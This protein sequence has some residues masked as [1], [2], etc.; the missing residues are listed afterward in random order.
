MNVN[1]S[2]ILFG[3]YDRSSCTFLFRGFLVFADLLA[4]EVRG[5][6]GLISWEGI[7]SSSKGKGKGM[8][9]EEP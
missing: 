3:E 1:C 9:L 5:L 6:G 4:K 8:Q 7:F 2:H